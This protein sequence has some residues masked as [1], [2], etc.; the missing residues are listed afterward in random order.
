M[1]NYYLEGK[2]IWRQFKTNVCSFFRVLVSNFYSF[3]AKFHAHHFEIGFATV[4]YSIGE[5]LPSL[6]PLF[7]GRF[8][9]QPLLR[10][11]FYEQSVYAAARTSRDDSKIAFSRTWLPA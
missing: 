7:S 8:L 2:K 3:P 5:M 9:H 10:D 1:F 6:S 4:F 11:A